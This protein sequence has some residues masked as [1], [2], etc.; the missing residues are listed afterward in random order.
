VEAK[1]PSAID[2]SDINELAEEEEEEVLNYL[3]IIYL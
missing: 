2:F 3:L 1:S